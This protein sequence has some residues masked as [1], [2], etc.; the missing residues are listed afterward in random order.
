MNVLPVTFVC[1]AAVHAA[2]SVPPRDHAAASA[3]G[4]IRGR[5]T[6]AATGL[7]L[8]RVR[9]TLT[10][11]ATNAPTTVTDTRG[12][13]ELIDIP[14]GLYS[15][16]AARA[17][18]LTLR[19]GQR[20]PREAG[21]AVEVRAGQT[22]ADIDL[23]MFRGATLS[24]RVSDELGDGAPGA[25]IE[26]IEFR[27]VRGRRI[28]VPAR[29]S[30]TNDAGE[31]RLGGLEP[32]VYQIRA[33]TVDVWEGD[34]GK[35]T[36]TYGATNFPGVAATDQPQGLTVAVGQELSG[37]D[38]QLIPGRAARITGVVE[39]ANGEPLA[40]QVVNLSRATRAVGGSLF[41][42]EGA[43]AAQTN[44]SGAFE[45]GKLAPGEYIVHS[46]GQSER[47]SV[48]VLVGESEVR[49]VVLTPRKPAGAGGSIE[50]DE[51]GPPTF[52]AARVS[53]SA[54]AIDAESALPSFTDPGPATARS[55]WTFRISSLDGKYLLRVNGLPDDWMLKA[56]LLGTR[57]VTDVP[58]SVTRSGGDVDGLR[59]ILSRKGSR[60]TGEVIDGSGRPTPDGTVILFPANQSLW[61][62]GSRFIKAVR[63]DARGRFSV[64][65]LPQGAYR[66]IA[67]DTV[68]EGQWEDPEFLQAALTGS[69]PV[70][71]GEGAAVAIKLTLEADR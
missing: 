9:I 21:R 34:D 70:E 30:T 6:S 68:L 20:R 17:G 54:L 23:P 66:A 55:D 44:A 47:T 67:R 18:Y 71:V 3:T 5:V 50:T 26:A 2:Q 37:L 8:H 63:P 11:G 69:V 27:Y 41:A 59:I 28:G 13:F 62:V 19:Y 49:H 61:D 64:G 16:T 33:T 48:S 14:P 57:D 4:T 38:F 12:E 10:G 36:L 45:F 22:V 42:T 58:I 35:S 53:I 25:R 29:I 52:P 40:A 43:G 1:I 32:G 39:N 24:G 15:V 51:Q 31:Y 46:G 7:P 56:V 65:G 60:V